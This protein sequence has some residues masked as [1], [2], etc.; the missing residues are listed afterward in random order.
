PTGGGS[1]SSTE[2]ARRDGEAG[3]Q[4]QGRH[5]RSGGENQEAGE[6]SRIHARGNAPAAIAPSEQSGSRQIGGDYRGRGAGARLRRCPRRSL[7]RLAIIE[8]PYDPQLAAAVA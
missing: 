1:A 4:A 2:A 7:M 6:G 3:G 5:E 8:G